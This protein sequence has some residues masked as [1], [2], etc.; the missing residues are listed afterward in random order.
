MIGVQETKIAFVCSQVR[1]GTDR[2]LAVT[3]QSLIAS[4]YRVTGAVQANIERAGRLRCDMDLT[5]LPDGP[6]VRISQDLGEHS[7]GCY[8]DSS[9]LEQ[10]VAAVEAQLFF[11]TDILIINKFGKRET[12]GGGFRPVIAEALER[13]IPV[14][15]GLSRLNAGDFDAFAGDL[16]VGL[17]DV[18]RVLERLDRWRPEAGTGRFS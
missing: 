18:R 16:A 11:N 8:L 12:E 1:G 15:V 7:R 2:V 17:P 3:A 4:G 9:A 5:V 10:V 6:A 14:L 13:K